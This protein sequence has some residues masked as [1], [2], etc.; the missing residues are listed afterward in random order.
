MKL[1]P[2]TNSLEENSAFL[3]AQDC[4]PI[5]DAMIDYYQEIG[6]NFPWI[7]YF[8]IDEHDNPVETGGFKGVPNNGE[9]EIAYHTFGMHEGKDIGTVI[10]KELVSIAR[11]SDPSV[12]IT[13][14]TLPDESPSCSILRKN[15]FTTLG[16]VIDPEDGE[17]FEWVIEKPIQ[18]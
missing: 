16:V 14:R 12:L 13:A 11:N 6:F 17:V 8:A 3:E 4:P 9:I 18:P 1:I 5:I 15:G 7:G 2:I 10:C